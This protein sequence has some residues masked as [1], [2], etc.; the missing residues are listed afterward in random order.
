MRAVFAGMLRRRSRAWIQNLA[1]AAASTALALAAGE[2]FLRRYLPAGGH[3]YRLHPRYHYTLAPHAR[4]LFVHARHNGGGLVLVTVNSQGFRGGEMRRG[5]EPRIVVYGDSCIEA[6]YSPVAL[7]FT[8]RLEAHLGAATGRPVETVNAGVNG[9]GPDQAQRRFEDEVRWLRPT[10]VVFTV[11]ADND[12]GDVVR[13]RLYQLEGDE[14]IDAGG[15][16]SEPVRRFFDP[17]GRGSGS[18]LWERVQHVVRRSRRTRRLT[19][20]DREERRQVALR[21][22]LETSEGLCRREYEE[23]VV[24][25]TAVVSEFVRDHYD[26]DVSFFPRSDA[27]AYKRRLLEAVL[28]RVR[29]TAAAEGVKLLVLVVPSPIDVCDGYEI[30][31][32]P[33]QYPEYDR[34][35]LTAEAAGA[36]RRAGLEVLDLFDPFASAGARD[37]YYRPPGEDHWNAAGQDLAARLVSERIVT[38]GWLD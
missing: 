23:L 33:R 10:G 36:A 30:R 3:L 25:G 19:A 38:E 35:R 17:A 32:D 28:R 18:V 13:N 26:A 20:E 24:K 12:F 21:R 37:L 27:A 29:A 7:T 22:Y 14:L 9:Y 11:F 2:W 6:D 5:G 16:L 15:V 34:R 8:K 4:S 1:L 31:V